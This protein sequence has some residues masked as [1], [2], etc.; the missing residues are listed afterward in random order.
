MT[1]PKRARG[2]F[3]ESTTPAASF[4]T[5]LRS[6]QSKVNPTRSGRAG[7]QSLGGE[8]VDSGRS[9]GSDFQR[10]LTQHDQGQIDIEGGRWAGDS[11][12][13]QRNQ[14]FL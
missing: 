13:R 8:W 2:G 9:H 12:A 7:G 14:I 6:F 5:A 1:S 11:P 10:K 3:L 4:P